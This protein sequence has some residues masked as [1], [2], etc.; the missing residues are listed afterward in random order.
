MALCGLDGH[1][2]DHHANGL[3]AL[4]LAQLQAWAHA[5]PSSHHKPRIGIAFGGGG[6]R[7]FVHLGVIRALEEAGIRA[8]V[9]TGSS[10]GAVAATLY[11]SGKPFSEI[12]RS[13][14]TV[15]E[16]DLADL[17][18]SRRGVLKGQA[19]ADWLNKTVGFDDLDAMPT[20]VGVAVT[21]LTNRQAVLVVKGNPGK[22]VQA[23]SSVPAAFVPVH[24]NGN[25]YIDGG[26][27]AL[28]PVRFVRALGADV[29]IAVDIY[30]GK[31]PAPVA[32][33]F[34]TTLHT[35]RLQTCALS[36][37]EATEADILIR[38]EFEPESFRNFK[39]RQH[40]I[41]MGYKAAQAMLPEL[42]ARL[43]RYPRP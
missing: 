38:P 35:F 14:H 8:D 3:Q 26:I 1:A 24:S 16:W 32:G 27:L 4:S 40:A 10:A 12:E 23:S 22:A 31:Q 5:T 33:M 11:A 18:F 20:P 39:S 21:D 29:V 7:G 43:A 6:V 36:A 30:C 25:V 41:D 28:V 42:K 34:Y 13:V 15:S 9:V 19:L 2:E 37:A 17:A